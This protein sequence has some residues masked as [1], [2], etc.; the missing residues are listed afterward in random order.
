MND[1]NNYAIKKVYFYIES[2]FW[3]KLD[4]TILQEWLSN[5]KTLEEKY[6]AL[7]LLDRFVY[8]SEDDIIRLLDYGFNEKIL[9]RQILKDEIN[10]SFNCKN[11]SIMDKKKSFMEEILILP[12]ITDNVSESSPAMARHLTN[13]L[14][15]PE[16]R[17]LDLNNLKSSDLNTAKRL[18]IIDDF[19]GTSNQIYTFWNET[20]IKIDGEEVFT[21][22]LKSRFTNLEIEYF[23]LV[24]TEEGFENF[25]IDNNAL[26]STGLKIT[27]CEMLSKKFKVFGET[28]VYFNKK[29]VE[30]CK[31]II[32]SLCSKNNIE[33]LGYKS[34]DYAIAFHHSIPDSSLPL[35]FKKRDSWN[36]LFK[37]KNTHN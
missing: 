30:I 1:F 21:N 6:C 26:G 2:K 13:D 17:I 36:P 14:G 9:K 37:N 22:K 25:N 27:Y 35:F 28:S 5:F 20:K 4:I 23:C 16:N 8:Y 34:L 12:L 18:I 11:T 31:N 29:E 10:N 33:L 19:I 24:C 3:S 7:K 32:E 15:F